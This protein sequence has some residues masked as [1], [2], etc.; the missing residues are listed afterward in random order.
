MVLARGPAEQLG[1][2]SDARLSFMQ[3]GMLS[4]RL[5]RLDDEPACA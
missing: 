1:V 5:L 4:D 2:A 3:P